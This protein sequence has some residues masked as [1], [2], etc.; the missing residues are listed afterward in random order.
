[1]TRQLS[2]VID[3]RPVGGRVGYDNVNPSDT[4][5][6]VASVAGGD[7]ALATAAVEAAAAAAAGWAAASP[8]HRSEIVDR[9]G[10]EIV[11]RYAELGD[12]LA[13]EEGK[14][15]AEAQGEAMRSGQMLKYAAGQALQVTG[16]H[17]P[18]VRPGV[19]VTVTRRPVGVVSLIT[20]FN[21]PLAIPALKIGP[22]LALGNAVVFK[23]ADQVC[24]SGAELVDILIRAGLP[25]GVLNL[26]LGDPVATGTVLTGHPSVAAV[27]ITGSV[28]T[29]RR[30]LESASAHG[31][32]VQLELG[33]KNPL[34][35]L[36]DADLSLAVDLAARGGWGSTGQRC[37]S[38]SFLVVDNGIHD[39]F[40]EALE[41]RR[42]RLTVDDARA[43]G[44]DMGPA[45]DDRQL[46]R[47]LGYLSVAAGE[48]GTVHGGEVLDRPKP[49]F[50]QA[51]ALVLGTTPDHTINREE[52]FG[53]VM[54]VIRVSGYEEALAVAN[55]SPYPLSAGIVTTRLA[56]ADHFRRHSRAGMVMVNLA[57]AGVDHHV[58]F[59]GSGASSYGPREQGSGA[60]DFFTETRTHYVASGPVA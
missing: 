8:L 19:E 54:S 48:G 58:P 7:A 35:V 28:P 50:Y 32:R 6:L 56:T 3:G 16:G 55:A 60:W 34:V 39:R 30:I 17:G 40:V 25:P 24:A 9:A 21:F 26:V 44:V 2:S 36:D 29:G 20:P 1:M 11:A 31:A 18:S 10:S 43:P 15:L 4:R 38:S 46:Q 22:A 37:T 51:P 52:V 53:P 5:D 59:G 49:G 23:P 12:L 45:I 27:S 47:T 57:T 14:T 13:Q 41:S 42:Q 33:G